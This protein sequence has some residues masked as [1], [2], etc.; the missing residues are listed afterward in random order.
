MASLNLAL[1]DDAEF[2][3]NDQQRERERERE[4]EGALKEIGMERE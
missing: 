3:L 4:R 2:L 1:S